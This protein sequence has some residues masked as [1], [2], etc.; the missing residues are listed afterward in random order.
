MESLAFVKSENFGNIKCDFWRKGNNEIFMT[1]GQLAQ[2][3][4]Y[5]SRDGLPSLV[6]KNE[7]LQQAEFSTIAILPTNEGETQET[8]IFTEDGIYEI[9]MLSRKPRAREFRTWVR[10]VLKALNKPYHTNNLKLSI[11]QQRAEAMLLNAKV[12][13]AKL[14]ME[15]KEDKNLPKAIEVLLSGG[16]K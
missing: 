3:L 7:Y 8:R 1:A 16:E 6:R 12:R 15:L 2:A 13:Q 5:T 10:Q 4:G 14:L 9:T 11:Q